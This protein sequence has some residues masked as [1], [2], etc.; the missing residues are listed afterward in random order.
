VY[1]CWKILEHTID[2][3]T[4]LILGEIASLV[5]MTRKRPTC[6]CGDPVDKE[7]FLCG[8]CTY[9]SGKANADC[10]LCLRPFAK[11]AQCKARVW[12]NGAAC[13][14]SH[15]ACADCVADGKHAQEGRASV[16][17]RLRKEVTDRDES[18][19]ARCGAEILNPKMGHI[20]P[21]VF[22]GP[23]TENNLRALCDACN[24]REITFHVHAY[25]R[26]TW[27]DGYDSGTRERLM[28]V[29]DTRMSAFLTRW[30]DVRAQRDA[31]RLEKDPRY[32]RVPP[33]RWPEAVHHL[34]GH[35]VQR[36]ESDRDER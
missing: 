16:S 31:K 28:I 7:G 11:K 8:W 23:E 2:P 3:S 32:A 30:E 24:K 6:G 18:R 35:P 27:W 10:V 36:E 29:Y 19:C 9:T 5:I 20:F 4:T 12:H 34:L 13:G 15:S 1:Y 22:G 33:A 25:D 26:P 14:M 17:S 21:N